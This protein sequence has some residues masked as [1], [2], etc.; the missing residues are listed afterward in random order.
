MSSDDRDSLLYSDGDVDNLLYSVSDV[1]DNL[2]YIVGDVVDNLLSIV[3]DVDDGD[4]GARIDTQKTCSGTDDDNSDDD[5]DDDGVDEG[6]A[7]GRLKVYEGARGDGRGIVQAGQEEAAATGKR[8]PREVTIIITIIITI[9][10]TIIII[11]ITNII[12]G[13]VKKWR[14]LKMATPIFF[15]VW[16]NIGPFGQNL[17]FALFLANCFGAKNQS[18][19]SYW[20]QIT[21]LPFIDICSGAPSK[22][23]STPPETLQWVTIL[24]IF[25]KPPKNQVN[26]IGLTSQKLHH[27]I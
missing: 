10:I 22:P 15:L 11:T 26:R 2:L 5:N 8:R 13:K 14:G 16:T 17:T 19:P 21:M 20:T 4:G 7:R 1:V 18:Q 27:I 6:R 24:M 25:L 12:K 23:T 9:L 3:G